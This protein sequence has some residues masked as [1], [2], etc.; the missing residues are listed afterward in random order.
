MT[1]TIIRILLLGAIVIGAA[2]AL[3]WVLQNGGDVPIQLNGKEYRP[4]LL[5]IILAIFAG[6]LLFW[7]FIKLVEFGLALV[8]FIMGDKNA[9]SK[10]FGRRRHKRG[11]EALQTSALAL[12]AGESKV[13]LKNAYRADKNLDYPIITNLLIAQAA[14]AEGKPAEA[15]AAYKKLL[16]TSKAGRYVA[17]RGL[18][19]E[20]QAVGDEET[21]AKL[22]QKALELNPKDKDTVNSLFNMQ[23]QEGNWEGARNTLKS[24]VKL[25]KL[26][27]DVARRREAVLAISEAKTLDRDADGEKYATLVNSAYRLAPGFVPAAIMSARLQADQ[28]NMRQANS[29]IVKAWNANPHPDLATAFAEFVPDETAEAR[30]RRF[31]VLT[32]RQSNDPETKMLKAEMLLAADDFPGARR[33]MGDLADNPK[34]SRQLSIMAAIEHGEGADETIVRAYLARASQASRGEQWVCDHCGEVH[35]EWE[36][37]CHNCKNFDTLE[38]KI[39]PEG[40]DSDAGI[41]VLLPLLMSSSKDS[42]ETADEIIEVEDAKVV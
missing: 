9:I 40:T 28:G 1:K 39:P 14:R 21:A 29:M 34:T 25:E 36:A 41:G 3:S 15:E 27:S 12:A 32:K 23:I 31:K 19:T 13:G 10:F 18:M 7:L 5:G 38:W 16:K 4:S 22:A 24:V 37:V 30:L 8:A 11:M 35:T 33:A 42:D 2:W 26:P 20:R 6:L 17:I